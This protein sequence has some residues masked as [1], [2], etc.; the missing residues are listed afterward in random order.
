MKISQ[1]NFT[2]SAKKTQKIQKLAK[3]KKLDIPKS[4]TYKHERGE[5]LV[6]IRQATSN[7][8]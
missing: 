3:L 1:K 2:T 4:F 5:V 8:K 7:D 6:D